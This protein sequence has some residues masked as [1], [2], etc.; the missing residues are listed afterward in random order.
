MG[1][2]IS[3]TLASGL[4]PSA[5][6]LDLP[7][8]RQWSVIPP[9]AGESVTTLSGGVAHS[10]WAPSVS[11]ATPEYSQ[12]ITEAQYA[13]L[14]RIY[15]H[16]TTRTWIIAIDGRVFEANIEI[17]RAERTRRNGIPMRDVACKIRIIREV[18]V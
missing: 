4:A 15:M 16:P 2:A 5:W 12:E 7:L 6:T 10:L 3:P 14:E 13:L 17:T 18:L 9:Q 1:F 11:A 8:P